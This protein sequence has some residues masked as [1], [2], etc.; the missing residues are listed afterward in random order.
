[1]SIDEI[2]KIFSKSQSSYEYMGGEFRI[3]LCPKALGSTKKYQ[4]NMTKYEEVFLSPRAWEEARNFS[5]VPGI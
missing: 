4:G 5:N 2:A 1:M 3:F